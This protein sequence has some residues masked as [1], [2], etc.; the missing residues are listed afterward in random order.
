MIDLNDK[1]ADT[2][3]S[4]LGLGFSINPIA[5]LAARL[6][7]GLHTRLARIGLGLV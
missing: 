2:S 5:F 3:S 1:R 7:L 4:D 6:G